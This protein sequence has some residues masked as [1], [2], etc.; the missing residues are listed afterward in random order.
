MSQQMR[1]K[2][3]KMYEKEGL[4]FLENNRRQVTVVSSGVKQSDY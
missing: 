2:A 3:D 4:L 1:S